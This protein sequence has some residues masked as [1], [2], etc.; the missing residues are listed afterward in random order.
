[1]NQIEDCVGQM[2]RS[3]EMLETPGTVSSEARRARRSAA[4]MAASQLGECIF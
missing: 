3:G 4:D 1:M 2:S